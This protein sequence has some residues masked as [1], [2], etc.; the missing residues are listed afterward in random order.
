MSDA[1]FKRRLAETAITHD[2]AKE[3]ASRLIAGSF[4]RKDLRPR[5]TIPTRHD[6]DD[7]LILEYIRRQRIVE[8]NAEQYDKDCID[9]RYQRD[10]AEE[11]ASSAEGA[12]AKLQTALKEAISLRVALYRH[13]DAEGEDSHLSDEKVAEKE[14]YARK[15]SAV[16]VETVPAK[17]D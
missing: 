12:I 1:E 5:F 15:W 6:D 17:P 7:V 3:I 14:S 4:N 9:M 8:S 11:R 13:G 2:D 16:L 10:A